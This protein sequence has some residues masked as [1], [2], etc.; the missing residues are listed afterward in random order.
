[1]KSFINFN[2]RLL[3]EQEPVIK[4]S[5]RSYRYGDGVFETIRVWKGKILLEELHFE[6][7]ME[8]MKTL[9]IQVP[10]LLT[11][12][13]LKNEIIELCGK[14]KCDEDARVRLSISRGHGGP[15]DSDGN[16]HY[17]IECSPLPGTAARL[18]ENGLVIDVF[19][20]ARKSIDIFS[21]LKSSSY[22]PYAMAAI[23]AKE[24]KLNDCL[25]LN[26]HDR[27]CDATIANMFWVKNKTV[28]TPPLSE[29][30][31][32]G[33]MRRRI[34]DFRSAISDLGLELKES[35]L[36]TNDLLSADEVFLTNAISGIRWV[37]QFREN[38]YQNKTSEKLFEKFILPLF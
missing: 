18:N 3:E 17:L 25:L 1:M 34:L 32:A 27:I 38:T 30:C 8:S 10:K 24:N 19:P 5:D 9:K 21:N 23:Y 31:V 16:F 26:S 4:A 6:R 20:Q 37:S 33:V 14:N 11:P 28:F 13:R 35:V 15:Y 7:L 12:E 36:T 29:G 2:G 22:L